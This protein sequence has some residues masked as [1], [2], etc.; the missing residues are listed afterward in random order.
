VVVDID[1]TVRQTYGYDKKGAGRGYTGV[2]GLNA[3]LAVVFTS[4]SAP[5]IA[6]TRPR[7]GS[8]N[9]ARGAAKLLTDTLAI[10]RRAGATGVAL[11]RS[12][13]AYHAHDIVAAVRRAGARFSITARS[14][15]PW[16][17]R[18]PASTNGPGPRSATRT[19]STT[20]TS[21]GGYRMPRML[22]SRPWL[23]IRQPL[24]R[25]RHR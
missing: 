15:R 2:K 11:V 24:S 20:R 8:T 4:L 3:L 22:A 23:R 14:P 1:D 18:S 6:A 9:S 16:S 13:S 21:S 12:D 5:L 10:L 19:R 17:R 7:K 25:R